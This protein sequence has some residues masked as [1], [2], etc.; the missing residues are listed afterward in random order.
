MDVNINEV[1]STV[2][3]VDGDGLLSPGTLETIV[4][5]VLEAMREQEAHAQR[6]K[7]E[8]RVTG[9]VRASSACCGGGK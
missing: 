5:A 3:T 4:R 9:S 7:A 1:V 8:Q 2:R 6:M